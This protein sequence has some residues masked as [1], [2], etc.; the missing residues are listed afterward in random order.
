M[1]DDLTNGLRW[2]YSS[3]CIVYT[4]CVCSILVVVRSCPFNVYCCHFGVINDYY[5]YN[6]RPNT[7]RRTSCAVW[8]RPYLHTISEAVQHKSSRPSHL[9]RFDHGFQ[10]GQQTHVFWHIGR[11]YLREI[12]AYCTLKLRA[13]G[14]YRFGF[15]LFRATVATRQ[16]IHDTNR[17]TRLAITHFSHKQSSVYCVLAMAL[18]HRDL[19]VCFST[20]FP[21]WCHKK[22]PKCYS[23]FGLSHLSS[24]RGDGRAVA[25]VQS[26]H[27]HY[28]ILLHVI[29]VCRMSRWSLTGPA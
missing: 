17:Y 23:D 5:A 25:P 27:R 21:R 3:R 28:C 14:E 22:T 12:I 9:L 19:V 7:L 20:V 15:T 13:F 4:V 16:I 8:R 11:Q 29:R 1:T 18:L 24:K 6:L 2:L 10:V 26:N